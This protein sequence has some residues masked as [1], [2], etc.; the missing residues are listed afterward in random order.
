VNFTP[1][2]EK[3]LTD[4]SFAGTFFSSFEDATA[5]ARRALPPAINGWLLFMAAQ[6]LNASNQ[7]LE[8]IRRM[9]TNDADL[10][11]AVQDLLDAFNANTTALEAEIESLKNKGLDGADPA[12]TSAVSNIENIVAKMKQS[13][14]DAQAAL[15][16]AAMPPS[17]D[18]TP[19][20]AP[21]SAGAAAGD[22][23]SA[24]A[25]TTDA[26]SSTG[27]TPGGDLPAGG[28]STDAGSTGSAGAS[29]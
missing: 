29:S 24:A 22:S 21:G 9:A 18:P 17:S 10:T 6:T 7:L 19:A 5:Y 3:T 27:S 13:T 2:L 23:S 12:I 28:S 11:Q 4:I 20:S 1:D 16:A 15:P 14:T 26:A 8:E 25:G